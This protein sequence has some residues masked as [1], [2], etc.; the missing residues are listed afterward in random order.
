MN[1]A[2]ATFSI[3]LPP[4]MA[5]ELDRARKVEH[6]TRSEFVR[7]ALRQYI[8]RGAALRRAKLRVAELPED[9]ATA[10]EIE[11]IEEARRAFREGQFVT[12]DQLRHELGRRAQQPR[13][14]KPPTRS[15]R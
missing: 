10:E 1:R 12:L 11:A 3:S 8:G 9:E 15:R 6:R 2:S 14:K 4:A 13:R 5:R 7:E